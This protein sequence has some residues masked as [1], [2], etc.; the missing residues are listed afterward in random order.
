[1]KKTFQE[2]L[3][4]LLNGRSYDEIE[5]VSGIP[6]E[7]LRRWKNGAN[8]VKSGAIVKLCTHFS[9]S[10]D[11]LLGLTDSMTGPPP[12]TADPPTSYSQAPPFQTTICPECNRIRSE[13]D[14]ME[15]RMESLQ[16]QNRELLDRLARP[17][18]PGTLDVTPA[19]PAK[20]RT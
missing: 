12:A 3:S 5:R 1:V 10:A 6:A 16:T 7:S 14:R 19:K 11:W 15:G 17:T 18:W 4:E 2:R 9:V 8:E 20:T 13:L